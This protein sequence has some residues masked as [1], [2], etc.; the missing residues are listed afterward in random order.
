MHALLLGV[1]YFWNFTMALVTKSIYIYIY[2]YF[3]HVVLH[4]VE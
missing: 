3:M 1:L 2:G 4:I